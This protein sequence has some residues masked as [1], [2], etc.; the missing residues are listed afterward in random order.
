MLTFKGRGHIV[1][2]VFLL[3]TFA[4]KD[5]SSLCRQIKTLSYCFKKILESIGR[6]PLFDKSMFGEYG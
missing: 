2:Y 3:A 4:E 5:F 6:L 1:E